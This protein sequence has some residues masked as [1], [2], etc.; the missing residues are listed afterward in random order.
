VRARHAA[1]R[2]RALF[3]KYNLITLAVVDEHGRLA[4]I[5]T[6]DDVIHDAAARTDGR[7]AFSKA[8]ARV[9]LCLAVVGPG[10]ITANVDNDAGGIAPTRWPARSSATRCCGR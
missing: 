3:D 10:F 9:A 4:G 6:A 1:G 5:I 7:H 2:S 8:G